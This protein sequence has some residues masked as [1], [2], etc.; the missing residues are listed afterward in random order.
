MRR[1]DN[2]QLKGTAVHEE[3]ASLRERPDNCSNKTVKKWY[4]TK[5]K[6]SHLE[7]NKKIFVVRGKIHQLDKEKDSGVMSDHRRS[8]R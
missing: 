8:C 2:A 3:S 1:V 7:I 6:N 5:C 4:F